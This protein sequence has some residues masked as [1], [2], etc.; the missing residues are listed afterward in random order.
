MMNKEQKKNYINDMESQFQNNDS[1]LVTPLLPEESTG[2]TIAGI[3]IS[4]S[5]NFASNGFQS[6]LF[7]LG[8]YFP[9]N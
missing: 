4:S 8:I 1:I 7:I 3:S 9:L 2:L 5:H 6:F